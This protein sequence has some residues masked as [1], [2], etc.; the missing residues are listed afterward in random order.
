MIRERRER[1]ALLFQL[2]HSSSAK[3]E[4]G[5]E[6]VRREG[7]RGGERD[8]RSMSSEELEE[9]RRRKRNK[10]K[11]MTASS[12][13]WSAASRTK[14]NGNSKKKGGKEEQLI[15]NFGLRQVKKRKRGGD[16]LVF[17]RLGTPMHRKKTEGKK[18]GATR[19][20]RKGKG[21]ER[22]IILLAARLIE[23]R[24]E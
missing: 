23:E 9:K 5:G 10:R 22:E 19:G 14:K 3:G 13:S 4:R 11:R 15:V 20:R 17:P 6:I 21:G 8:V 16:L 12:R 2:R 18:E 24:W 1:R 7:E